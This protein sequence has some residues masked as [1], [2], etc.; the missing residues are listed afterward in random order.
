MKRSMRTVFLSILI[1]LLMITVIAC[2]DRDAEGGTETSD[3]TPLDSSGED[4][5]EETTKNHTKG[6]SGDDDDDGKKEDE[7]TTSPVVEE[8]PETTKEMVDLSEY[9]VIY[10]SSVTT[11][12]RRKIT[13]TVAQIKDIT[14][15]N[16]SYGND[17]A[18]PAD[19]ANKE[20]LVDITNRPESIALNESLENQLS[21]IIKHSENKIIICAGSTKAL[22]QALEYF[23]ALIDASDKLEIEK[24]YYYAGSY[25]MSPTMTSIIKNYKIVYG[26]GNLYCES[27]VA[28]TMTSLMDK[29]SVTANVAS[30]DTDVAESGKEVLIGGT[31]RQKSAEAMENIGFYEYRIIVDEGD[32]VLVAGGELA[33][34]WGYE[35]LIRMIGSDEL[36][37]TKNSEKSEIFEMKNHFDFDSFV[38]SWSS[39]RTPTAWLSNVDGSNFMEKAYALTATCSKTTALNTG[40]TRITSQSHRGD[41]IYY[42]EGSLESI[43]SCIWMGIDVVEIDVQK[44]KDGIIIWH[45]DTTLYDMTNAHQYVGKPGY[46][47]TYNISDWTYEQICDLRLLSGLGRNNPGGTFTVTDYMIPTAY[48]VFQLCAGRVFIQID[49]KETTIETHGWYNMAAAAGAKEC[50]IT[51]HEGSSRGR[52]TSQHTN[53]LNIMDTWLS[54]DPT[55][56][57]FAE[58]MTTIHEWTDEN[59]AIIRGEPYWPAPENNYTSWKGHAYQVEEDATWNTMVSEGYYHMWTENPLA[60]IT[61]I[62]N[63]CAAVNLPT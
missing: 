59:G 50:F 56:T 31:N 15:I 48:E 54:Y 45:H 47:A 55:D 1:I 27:T 44:T 34:Q 10:S 20:I 46:P 57:E 43:A 19:T 7:T 29:Y 42:S 33:L 35:E 39:D 60:L 61:Y 2:E 22:E 30:K 53:M 12:V 4:T 51:E 52:K 62:E 38:P 18:N 58:F 14:N 32:I 23:V 16:L 37:L 9:K 49:E 26:S 24:N 63:N 25:S 40:V 11:D 41:V 13:D 21:F 28:Q 3:V 36:D 6:D 5:S 8:E 17:Y